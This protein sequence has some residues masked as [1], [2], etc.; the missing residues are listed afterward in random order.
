MHFDNRHG[1]T[2]R[3]TGSANVSNW[4]SGEQPASVGL[5]ICRLRIIYARHRGRIDSIAAMDP[6]NRVREAAFLLAAR[7]RLPATRQLHPHLIGMVLVWVGNRNNR[8]N[9]SPEPIMARR[10]YRS[11]PL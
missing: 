10:R 6:Q 5:K 4:Q 9:V 11:R 2:S 8:A 3:N 7:W 1:D